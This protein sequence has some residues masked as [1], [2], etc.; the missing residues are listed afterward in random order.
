MRTEDRIYYCSNTSAACAAILRDG[1]T[2]EPEL[3]PSTGK[4]GVYLSDCPGEPDPEY[5]DDQLLEITLPP[6]ISIS[7]FEIFISKEGTPAL[8]RIRRSRAHTQRIGRGSFSAKNKVE[9]KV[10]AMEE[11]QLY[12]NAQRTGG[13]RSAG[14]RQ[15]RARTTSIS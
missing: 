6:E 1:F 4:I 11:R 12:R 5:P 7:Q 3:Q 2:D 9:P 8:A 10:E 15:R 13:R 14:A